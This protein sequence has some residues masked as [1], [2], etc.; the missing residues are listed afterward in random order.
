MPG[1]D[2]TIYEQLSGEVPGNEKS[3]IAK[4]IRAQCVGETINITE[5]QK[6]L[7]KDLE[8]VH[9]ARSKWGSLTQEQLDR[10]GWDQSVHGGQRVKFITRFITING[11]D[12]LLDL[13][14]EKPVPVLHWAKIKEGFLTNINAI[15]TGVEDKVK[16][17]SW[18]KR[19]MGVGTGGVTFKELM[20]T[21][22]DLEGELNHFSLRSEFLSHF[23]CAFQSSFNSFATK[24]FL[25]KE[26]SFQQRILHPHSY[27]RGEDLESIE[28]CRQAL[29]ST[30]FFREQASMVDN[31]IEIYR[32]S[33]IYLR[34]DVPGSK[35]ILNQAELRELSE[36]TNGSMEKTLDVFCENLPETFASISTAQSA[37]LDSVLVAKEIRDFAQGRSNEQ[38]SKSVI[39]LAVK[40]GTERAIKSLQNNLSM[41]SVTS[42]VSKAVNAP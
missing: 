38:S 36:L 8:L 3:I 10:L 28:E 19:K 7:K 40:K 42:T 11:P 23:V 24:K 34:Q 5:A 14:N 33:E 26:T 15:K 2:S 4:L 25:D 27:K 30:G 1:S 12:E 13:L 31:L 18:H 21:I 39:S 41:K 20:K 37:I 22:E 32:L 9:I 35:S 16:A 17:I 29:L 6:R